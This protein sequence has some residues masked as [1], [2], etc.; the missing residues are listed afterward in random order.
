MDLLMRTAIVTLTCALLL[1]FPA[2][3]DTLRLSEPVV[4][5]ATTETFGAVLDER[6]PRLAL[7]D[8][9]ADAPKYVDQPVLVETRVGKVCQKKG[10]FF[11]ATQGELALRVSFRD[12]GFFVPTDT[13]GK[14]VTLAGQLIQ[15]E[16]SPEQAEHYNSDL[17]DGTTTLAPGVVYEIVADA[18]RIPK[19]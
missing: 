2:F 16:L 3:A 14:T 4:S 13:S 1:S 17:R 6:L 15:R 9:I 18:V 10:C 19:S 11:L 12:Y 7:A 5:T 8:L